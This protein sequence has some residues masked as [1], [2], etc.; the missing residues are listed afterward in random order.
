MAQLLPNIAALHR[1]KLLIV[2]S[3]ILT[4]KRIIVWGWSAVLTTIKN[5]YYIPCN[6]S[7]PILR[8]YT[9]NLPLPLKFSMKQGLILI[10]SSWLESKCEKEEHIVNFSSSP[11]SGAPRTNSSSFA[12]PNY[13]EGAWGSGLEHHSQSRNSHG[14]VV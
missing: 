10:L 14:P 2:H 9:S 6:K 11:P 12:A 8:L 4:G 1:N 7:C 13:E 3:K 5:I